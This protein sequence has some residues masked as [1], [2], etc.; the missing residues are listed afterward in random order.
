MEI[1]PGEKWETWEP[2]GELLVQGEGGE[3]EIHAAV[4]EQARAKLLH[5]HLDTTVTP[6]TTSGGAP[7][8]SHARGGAVA[9]R[10]RPAHARG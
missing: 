4:D 7:R 6:T 8:R 5:S 1:E 10:A 9:G 2:Y 3:M